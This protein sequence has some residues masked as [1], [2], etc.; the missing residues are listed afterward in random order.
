MTITVCIPY[1]NRPVQ[2]RECVAALQA[3]NILTSYDVVI[4]VPEAEVLDVQTILRDFT[5]L[6]FQAASFSGQWS[7][8]KAR[9][10]AIRKAKGDILLLLDSDIRLEPTVVAAHLEWH[11]NQ[12]AVG[13]RILLGGVYGYDKLLDYNVADIN[14]PAQDLLA[15][16]RREGINFSEVSMPWSMC[17]TG[18]LSLSRSA[19]EK[20]GVWFDEEFSGW[21]MEDQEWAF[22]LWKAGF[23]IDC[24]CSL[25][26]YHIP[27]Q[28]QVA[29]NLAEE[30]K[31]LSRFLHKHS[32]ME[33]EMVAAF[34]DIQA[35]SLSSR[36]FRAIH[37]ANEKC[38]VPCE[39]TMGASVKDKN[40]LFIGV[41]LS[42]FPVTGTVLDPILCEGDRRVSSSVTSYPLFGIKTPFPAHAFERVIISEK[43]SDLDSL[44]LDRLL[45]EALRV[46][47]YPLDGVWWCSGRRVALLE[48]GL[49][50]V[51]HKTGIP[52]GERSA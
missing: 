27:H 26:G 36:V 52:G 24:D 22:R 5:G 29:A 23:S 8:S 10:T 3:Q 28:R 11:R 47:C 37:K 17:W 9:N 4:G 16:D 7:I 44:L 20:D 49:T 25:R 35:H 46:C 21:G 13:K 41:P 33:V 18:H 15:P 30:E 45:R 50:P 39:F 14:P 6:L 42:G 19:L 34:G 1:S 12:L 48:I 32:C 2:L 51:K 38:R 40:T 31:N 43:Y